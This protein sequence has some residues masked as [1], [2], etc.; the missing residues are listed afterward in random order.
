M[1]VERTMMVTTIVCWGLA[2]AAVGVR[3][4]LD[5]PDLADVA[6][7]LFLI[8]AL[9]WAAPPI[10]AIALLGG[11]KAMESVRRGARRRREHG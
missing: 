11:H 10:V 8:G 7:L 1:R 3:Q 6:L 2:A 5:A 4:L 9:V